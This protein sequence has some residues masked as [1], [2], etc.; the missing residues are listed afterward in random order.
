MKDNKRILLLSVIVLG[1]FVHAAALFTLHMMPLHLPTATYQNMISHEESTKDYFN[2]QMRSEALAEIF[3]N[4]QEAEP[5]VK[6]QFHELSAE[7]A[8]ALEI[9]LGDR[10]PVDL[11]IEPFALDPALHPTLSEEG[12]L[13]L[14]EG[15]RLI[16]DMPLV[17]SIELPPLAEVDYEDDPYTSFGTLAG[18]EHFDINVEYAP[19]RHRP[20]YVFKITFSPKEEIDFKRIRQNIFFLIDRS[21]SIPRARYALNKQAVSA[22]LDYLKEGDTFNILIFDGRVVRMA[23]DPVP[24]SDETVAEA[25]A[26]LDRHGHG[27]HF[28]ATELYAS[29]GK[30]IPQDVS[31]HEVNTAI[32]LSDGDTYLS[33]EKQRQMIGGWTKLNAG[34]VSLYCVA[35]GTGNNLPLLDLISSFN[36]GRLIYSQDHNELTPMMKNLIETIHAPIGKDMV[37]TAI[38]ADKQTNILLQPKAV[39]LP[40]LYQYRPFVVYGSTNRLTDFVLFLQ[41]KYYDQRFDIKKKISFA[42]LPIGSFSIERTWTQ[43]LAHECY[44]SYLED[45][46]REH[47]EVAKQ[48]LLPLNLPTPWVER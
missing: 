28:A 41:G 36:Q 32:L 11:E 20:G 7:Y 34:K 13:S 26:F 40:D 46:N 44:S 15:S 1:L 10:T 31:D 4:L 14:Q 38:T 9:A 33:Q 45:G 3:N 18:S 27:G 29:L 23:L 43:L 39:R 24:W 19:K 2:R 47:L 25:R 17:T 5:E 37:A 22:S 8:P 30:I 6:Q 12:E 16:S 35:S 48:L 42:N 21:N